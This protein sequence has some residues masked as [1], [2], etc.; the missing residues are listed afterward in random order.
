MSIALAIS[1]ARA[2]DE[3]RESSG[4][5]FVDR[6]DAL[7]ARA[8][9]PALTIGQQGEQ[10]LGIAFRDAFDRAV[11]AIAYPAHEAEFASALHDRRSEEH[12]LDAPSYDRM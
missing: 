7:D 9:W 12:S 3:R 10:A 8:L 1:S 5:W 6:L 4:F 2:H 11:V